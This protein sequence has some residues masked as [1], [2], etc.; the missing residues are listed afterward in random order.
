MKHLNH[1]TDDAI[2][3]ISKIIDN[4]SETADKEIL[5]RRRKA[6]EIGS[7]KPN[8]LTY[9]ERCHSILNK[10]KKS[11]SDYDTNFNNDQWTDIKLSI[12]SVTITEE[13]DKTDFKKLYLYRNNYIQ[14]LCNNLRK[15]NNGEWMCP[16]CQV[17]PVN[18]LDHYIP[19]TK[20]PLY[21]VHPRNLIPC[22]TTC[23]G[24]KS[25]KVVEEGKRVYWNAFLDSV[26]QRYLYCDITIENGIPACNFSTKKGDLSDE[27]Y[28]VIKTTFDDLHVADT[29]R[30]GVSCFVTELRDTI[31]ENLIKKNF[32]SLEQCIC[33][34]KQLYQPKNVNDVR[35]IAQLALLDSP[36]F[37]KVVDNDLVSCKNI[38][39]MDISP[40]IA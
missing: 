30:D 6:E 9:Q 39:S 26:E 10:N 27:L 29:M 16:I 36:A 34:I 7:S 32:E 17:T 21:A 40:L 18:S 33:E 14:E 4:K 11:I 28:K 2:L 35:K 19:K 13:N 24:H 15:L 5:A 3:F 22:C 12:P 20:Y 38:S 31:V 25:E 37:L 1:T 23:N 8:E